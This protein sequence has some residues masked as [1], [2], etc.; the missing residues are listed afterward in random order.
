VGSR[1]IGDHEV[2]WAI[3]HVTA[4]VHEILVQM[5]AREKVKTRLENL[6]YQLDVGIRGS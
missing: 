2:M 3:E 5:P 6:M 4:E 1:A